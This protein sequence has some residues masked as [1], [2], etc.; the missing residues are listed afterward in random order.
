MSAWQV[1][2]D[3]EDDEE[4]LPPK[5]SSWDSEEIEKEEVLLSSLDQIVGASSRICLTVRSDAEVFVPPILFSPP[6]THITDQSQQQL[7]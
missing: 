3:E 6:P 4:G 5:P 2:E 7:R 1:E